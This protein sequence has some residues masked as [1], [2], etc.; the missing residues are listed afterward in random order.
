MS[1][2]PARTKAKSVLQARI[3]TDAYQSVRV[4]RTHP[5][6]LF[7]SFSHLF[8]TLIFWIQG[9]YI[10]DVDQDALRILYGI[11]V[12]NIS[13]FPDTRKTLQHHNLRATI[14]SEAIAFLNMLATRYQHL[15]ASRAELIELVLLYAGSFCTDEVHTDYLMQRLQQVVENHPRRY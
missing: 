13:E 10:E 12:K 1:G 15:F 5:L 14:D 4:L 3:S 2:K 11:K 6:G 9:I 8:E 7:H